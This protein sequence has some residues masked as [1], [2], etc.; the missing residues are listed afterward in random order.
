MLFEEY[1]GAPLIYNQ[2][3]TLFFFSKISSIVIFKDIEYNL[4]KSYKYNLPLFDF[5]I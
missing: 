1:H 3:S 4:I 5:G 2:S